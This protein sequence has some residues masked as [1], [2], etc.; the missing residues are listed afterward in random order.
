M[1][2]PHATRQVRRLQRALKRENNA[3]MRQRI[4]MVLLDNFLSSDPGDFLG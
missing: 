2:F 4:Q 1:K 3:K